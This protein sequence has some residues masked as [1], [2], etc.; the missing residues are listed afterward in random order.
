MVG[1]EPDQRLEQRRRELE[2]EGDEAD[3]REIQREVGL[4]HRVHRRQQRLHHV[5]E[6]M[7]EAD[8]EQDG[9]RG[10]GLKRL[11]SRSTARLFD[12]MVSSA[13]KTPF[14]PMFEPLGGGA[15]ISLRTVSW[16]VPSFT[17]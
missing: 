7:A 6:Q 14:T 1:V 17:W 9:E 16:P 11:C 4:E 8:G 13:S 10:H 12:P 5:V 2:G 15:P 3:L